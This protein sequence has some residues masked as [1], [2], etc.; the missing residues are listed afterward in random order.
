V[1]GWLGSTTLVVALPGS[2]RV[3]SVR[4]RDPQLL[5]FA[6]ALSERLMLA[7]K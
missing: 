4:G 3:Y 2:E 1:F 6:E 7:H 5:E